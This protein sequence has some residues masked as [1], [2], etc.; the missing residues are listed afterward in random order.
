[1]ILYFAAVCSSMIN[2][3]HNSVDRI[4]FYHWFQY[5]CRFG[6]AKFFILLVIFILAEGLTYVGLAWVAAEFFES[7]SYMREC[8][9]GFSGEHWHFKKCML[10]QGF[11][12][13][14]IMWI[15]YLWNEEVNLTDNTGNTGSN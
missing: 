14:C 9:I 3:F 10:Y 1:M 6:S 11:V 8:A 15:S 7:Y 12:D 5:F 13:V 2:Q 4:I